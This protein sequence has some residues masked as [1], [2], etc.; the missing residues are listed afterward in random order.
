M[1]NNDLYCPIC[2]CDDEESK[3]EVFGRTP[4]LHTFHSS[5]WATWIAEGKLRCPTCNRP[6]VGPELELTPPEVCPAPRIL[7]DDA[8]ENNTDD[9]QNLELEGEYQGSTYTYTSSNDLAVVDRNNGIREGVNTENNTENSSSLPNAP[10][11]PDS[12]DEDRE[13]VDDEDSV[14]EELSHSTSYTYYTTAT[15]TATFTC[16]T[17]ST[18]VQ[19]A[20]LQIPDF[21]GLTIS[22]PAEDEGIPPPPSAE[23]FL[24]AVYDQL[25]VQEVE[26]GWEVHT[27]VRS[28]LNQ[29]LCLSVASSIIHGMSGNVPATNSSQLHDVAEAFG[30]ALTAAVPQ[31]LH[32]TLG[33][34][35]V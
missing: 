32:E 31:Q 9:P 16:V 25:Q 24:S 8:N 14:D 2:L 21:V 29:C 1:E 5:C 11:S 20:P 34:T 6:L 33:L 35:P 7:E 17:Q 4:C 28:N 18:L 26:C 19:T 27:Q 10:S 13:G 23:L 30:T 15:D 12:S 22:E 3:G